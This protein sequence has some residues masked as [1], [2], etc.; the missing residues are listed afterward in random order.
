MH[1]ISMSDDESI[2]AHE[3]IIKESHMRLKIARR[4][5]PNV[6]YY[7]TN[8][9]CFG[10]KDVDEL[11]KIYTT[12]VSCIKGEDDEQKRKTY[13][14]VCL[15]LHESILVKLVS[16][17]YGGSTINML[18]SSNLTS[19]QMLMHCDYY[20]HILKENAAEDDIS[21]LVRE[22]YAHTLIAEELGYGNFL[23]K[24][25]VTTFFSQYITVEP[26]C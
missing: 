21:D 22:T 18:N 19:I 20:N 26:S 25:C 10:V 15:S 8:D 17:R 6:F 2:R 5:Y 16:D 14:V 1:V 7:V 4:A 12:I 9:D 3:D 13:V 11:T 24:E 23:I